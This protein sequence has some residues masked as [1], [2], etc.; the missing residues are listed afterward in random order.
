MEVIPS[1][2]GG[3]FAAAFALA[4]PVGWHRRSAAD[5]DIV[6]NEII[7]PPDERRISVRGDLQSRR[8]AGGPSMAFTEASDC[9]PR[10]GEDRTGCGSSSAAMSEFSAAGDHRRG[11]VLG[12][13]IIR[14]SD[15]TLERAEAGCRLGQIFDRG[16]GQSRR[17][18]TRPR[19]SGFLRTRRDR[20]PR[21]G[22]P[23][24][25]PPRR[26][27]AERQGKGTT[28]FRRIS[29]RWLRGLSARRRFQRQDSP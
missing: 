5:S 9:V 13:L 18:G 29:R 15:R 7:H 26:E 14:R 20:E 24:E 19:W 17:M 2:P 10:P 21:I 8:V 12:K 16:N 28:V 1:L 11:R 6:I 22:R 23:P 27:Q 4:F 25:C 3:Y